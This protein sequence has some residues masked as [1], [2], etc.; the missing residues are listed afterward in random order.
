MAQIIWLV[1]ATVMIV[2]E[3]IT[4]GLTTI[5]FAGGAFIAALAAWIGA[6][7]LI[8]IVM[9]AAV[10]L[11]LLVFTRP[12]A[13]K[14]I[15]KDIEKTNVEGLIGMVGLVTTTIDNIK[16]EGVVRLDGKEWWSRSA[17]GSVIEAG[18]QVVVTEISGVK[19]IV[20]QSNIKG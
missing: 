8:Q 3:I 10:S 20:K 15:M 17:D 2:I 9:F 14:K 4:L 11:V 7:W 18:A 13:A 6:H 16:S 5:W 12:I 1:I 19:L